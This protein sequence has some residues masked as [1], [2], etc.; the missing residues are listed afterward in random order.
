MPRFIN[1]HFIGGCVGY[2]KLNRRV[3]PDAIFPLLSN[4]LRCY[5]GEEF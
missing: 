3:S 2:P 5:N 4:P 1:G